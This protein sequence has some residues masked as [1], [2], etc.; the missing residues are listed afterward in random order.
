[1]TAIET[2]ACR[3]LTVVRPSRPPARIGARPPTPFLASLVADVGRGK[4]YERA[5]RAIDLYQARAVVIFRR[6]ARLDR[7]C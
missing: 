4:R 3:A 1:M 6:T 5:R 7:R 2:S